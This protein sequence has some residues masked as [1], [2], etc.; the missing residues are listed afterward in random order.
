MN[1]DLVK[2]KRKLLGLSRL[3][4]KINKLAG[5]GLSSWSV[6]VKLLNGKVVTE[7]TVIDLN[8]LIQ[9]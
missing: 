5:A 4:F 2:A 6:Y 9:W 7:H 3:G 1:E 8:N